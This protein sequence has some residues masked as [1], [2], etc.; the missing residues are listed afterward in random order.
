MADPLSFGKVVGKHPRVRKRKCG[1]DLYKG[2]LAE[3]VLEGGNP[4][5]LGG[6]EFAFEIVEAMD[7]YRASKNEKSLKHFLDDVNRLLKT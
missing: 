3:A 5:T 1:R 2:I 4:A 7:L 6:L